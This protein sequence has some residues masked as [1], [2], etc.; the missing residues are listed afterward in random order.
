[1]FYFFDKFHLRETY[2]ISNEAFYKFIYTISS[3]YNDVPYHNWTHACDVMQYIFYLSTNSHFDQRLTS[4]ELYAMLIAAICH[5][6]NHRGFNN[7]FNVKVETPGLGLLFK[8]K[9]LMEMHH[10]ETSIPIME[11]NDINLFH[12]FDFADTKKVYNLFIQTIL[13]ADMAHHFEL[14]K[15]AQGLLD[16][17]KWNWDE[18]DVRVLA[19]QLVLKFA[20]ISNVSRPFE[21]ADK[22]CDIL[23]QEFFRSG[24]LEKSTGIGLTSPLN[25]RDTAKKP[26]SQIGFY[27]FICLPLYT[28]VANIVPELQV[29][30]DSLKSNLEHWRPQVNHNSITML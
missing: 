28:A 19:L 9:S 7:V 1:M 2:K 16:E 3:T 29:N 25:D 11:Q 15:K 10:I 23:N 26:K 17:G 30:V 4:M 13:A 18:Y 27:N 6:A 12:S 21:I 20:D 14:V 5:D 24:D 8:D 22:W